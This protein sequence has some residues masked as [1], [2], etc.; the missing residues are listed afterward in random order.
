V[1]L[2]KIKESHLKFRKTILL[3]VAVSLIALFPC[4]ILGYV[5][6]DDDILNYNSIV[7]QFFKSSIS[8]GHLPLWNPYLFAGQPFWAD[9]SSMVCYPFLYP[10]L[11]FPTAYGLGVF[12][13]L[14]LVIA[15]L[16]MRYWL[17]NFN[18]SEESCWVGSVSFALSGFYWS[19][20]PH[21]MCVACYSWI[22][23]FM[24]S[25]ENLIASSN[26]KYGFLTGLFFSFLFLTGC[27]QIILGTLYFGF[28]YSFF[29][30]W[31][32]RQKLK[33]PKGI[34]WAS[35][36]TCFLLII[37]GALPFLFLWIPASEFMGFSDRLHATLSYE[38]F[39]AGLSIKPQNLYQFLFPVHPDVPAQGSAWPYEDF[40]GNAGHL[41]IWAPFFILAA[42]RRKKT[43][44]PFFLSGIAFLT[45]LVCLGKYF[46]I[47]RL[48]TEW[49]PGFRLIRGP[50]RFLFLYSACVSILIGFGFEELSKKGAQKTK[51]YFI[52]WVF[53][54]TV[55][56]LTA[57]FGNPPAILSQTIF[58][59]FG[60][61]G[62]YQWLRR[63]PLSSAGKY[64]FLFSIFLSL[65]WGGCLPVLHD[66]AQ[67]P[68]W[69]FRK[70]PV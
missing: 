6:F 15:A 13:F 17:K 45:V 57:F 14:H 54:G 1:A 48:I 55:L 47:H 21:P 8:S 32:I 3:Y 24:G 50:F 40:V 51:P 7:R 22:P 29:R 37:W 63:G 34:E 18:L 52:L 46:F 39:N 19:E 42:F 16:G 28:V 36:S 70:K 68:T 60:T 56:I 43:K 12:N 41:G 5:Y 2:K 69:T 49:A 64:G 33:T 23:W 62:L 11:L 38:N 30:V 25:L 65:L 35:T 10:T 26:R 67:P 9:P 20:I 31:S 59:V 66:W 53:A 27:F 58:W 4:L 61:A 44:W